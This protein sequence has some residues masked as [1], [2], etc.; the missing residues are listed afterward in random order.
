MKDLTQGSVPRH[1]AQLAIPMAMGMLLQTLYFFVDL[2]FVSR[3]GDAAIAGVSAAGN[4]MFV[5][6]A[7]NQMLQSG[8]ASMISH[9]VG[10]KD[11]A[12]ANHIFNQSL[13]MAMACV[14][15]TLVGGYAII[16]P[17][18]NFFGTDAASRDAGATF[19]RWVIPGIAIQYPMAVMGA[20]LRG[21]GIVKPTM[22]V[23][24]L[25]VV[26]NIVFAPI[27]VAG[28]GTG[29]PL[30]VAGAALA[31]TASSFIG[32]IVTLV[33]F[34][35]V[36]HY[37]GFDAS[38]WRP[39]GATWAKLFNIGLPS[40]GEFLLLAVTSATMYWAARGFGTEAQA[41]VGI[42]FRINQMLFVPV[43]AVAIACSPLA[44]QNYGARNAQRVRDTLRYAILMAGALMV[45][46]T[47]FVQVFAEWLARIF[48][49]EAAVLAYTVTFL[50]FLGWNFLPSGVAM[51]CSNLFQAIGNT[52]PA[53]ASTAAR[54]G[55][56]LLAAV[57]LSSQPWFQL[58]HLFAASVSTVMFQALLVYFWLRREMD[59]RLVF[60]A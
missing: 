42:G 46:L 57:W 28:W 59:R 31:T 53:L 54:V 50:H 45:G 25:I 15:I 18:T 32:L 43:M 6:F 12:G 5:G 29:V 47:I 10:R 7:F 35:K 9:A 8:A 41:G 30:G 44:G 58:W 56:F 26:L 14:L 16:T 21:T 34:I 2:Y 39:Q 11:Q 3:L 20:G 1:L 13:A 23:Q 36:E 27:L 37:I 55:L 52:W 4:V 40:G 22:I 60:K 19:L 48:T 49:N 24:A 17:Y 38:D 51:V 33:Y